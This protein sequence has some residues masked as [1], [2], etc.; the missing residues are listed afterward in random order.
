M[1]IKLRLFGIV[2]E[3]AGF[4]DQVVE[5]IA[6]TKELKEYLFQNHPAIESLTFSLAVNQAITTE[7]CD[8]SDDDEV[9][10]LPP[11]SGG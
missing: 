1:Q 3:K 10:L 7:E 6:G 9:A 11:F 8:L 4:E 2:A 5:G